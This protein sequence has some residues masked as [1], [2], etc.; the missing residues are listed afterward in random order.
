MNIKFHT[1]TLTNGLRVIINSDSSTS[2]AA[3]NLLYNVGSK[4]ESPERT[5]FAHLF[6]HLMFGGSLN[7][8]SFD[9]PLEKAGG[10]NNAF[11]NNDFTSYYMTLPAANLEIS[12]W[13]ESDRMLG[14]NFSQQKLDVQKNVVIEEYKQRY[15]NRPYGDVW[16]LLRPLA[17]KVHPYQWPTIGKNI[18]HIE[19]TTLQEV[20]QFFYTHYAPNNAIL[21][22]SGNVEIDHV[23]ALA[24][25]WFGEIPNRSIPANTIAKEPLQKNEQ[26][27]NVERDVPFDAMYKVYHMCSRNHPDFYATD[28]ISDI[29]S[30]GNSSRLYQSL[31]KQ[32]KLF[33]QLD[34]YISGELEEGLFV[35]SG[36]L[37]KNVSMKDADE[38][39]SEEIE[40]MKTSLPEG[41]ELEKVKNKFEA[42]HIYNNTETQNRAIHL[43]F[44]ELL[45]DAGFINH[46]VE[47]YRSVTPEQVQQTANNVFKPQNCSTLYYHS[48]TK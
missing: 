47:N 17:Y 26:Y 7:I 39:I 29:L 37:N 1:E 43:S 36:K 2:L 11:T 27:L 31:V 23:L 24:D 6:E 34:A 48:K 19:N 12:F 38:A 22:V 3:V 46:E 9:T 32:K 15:L 35:F 41:K 16:L 25:K 42:N 44:Y 20:K 10:T 14:L 40:K 45:G 21:T 30:N 28:M 5:G 4:H 33:Y 18:S 13:L 8:P